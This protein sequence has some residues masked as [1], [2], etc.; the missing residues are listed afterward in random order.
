MAENKKYLDMQGLTYFYNQIKSKFASKTDVSAP[1]TA[2]TIAAM[3]NHDKVYV[4][5]GSET[6]HTY[7]DWYFYED[8]SWH[9]GGQYRANVYE[10][11][12]TLS[13]SDKPAD[14]KKTGDEITNLKSAFDGITENKNVTPLTSTGY[15]IA[16]NGN[17]TANSNFDIKKYPVTPGVLMYLDIGFPYQSSGGVFQF[18]TNASIPLSNNQNIVG[19]THT[20]AF[21][22]EI[23]VPNTAQWLVIT[24]KANVEDTNT[25]QEVYPKDYE[26]NNIYNLI[27]DINFGSITKNARNILINILQKAIY[28]TNISA[29][30]D[31]LNRNL[32]YPGELVVKS[33]GK[34]FNQYGSTVDDQYS[35][36]TEYY[37]VEQGATKIMVYFAVDDL[38]QISS[39]INVEIDDNGDVLG[40]YNMNNSGRQNVE[41]ERTINSSATYLGF[42]LNLASLQKSYAYFKTS[43]N[44][45]FAGSL[46][47][48]AGMKNIFQ[49]RG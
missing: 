20:N 2:S 41:Y 34:K 48:Y 10:T 32:I 4:Y 28:N 29:D 25:I 19:E 6:G 47:P 17:A 39:P 18:Q 1:S 37:P 45:L 24:V 8:G 40:Y 9:S 16:S 46:S 31:K 14:G 7:G 22:G 35:V 5:T 33:T 38:T 42:T 43:G 30:I 12:K 36:V 26:S 23:I 13:V 49:K 27:D 15:Y 11:D 3:T 21:S 44:I